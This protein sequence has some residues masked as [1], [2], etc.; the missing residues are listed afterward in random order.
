MN[1]EEDVQIWMDAY[2]AGTASPDVVA[3]LNRALKEDEALRI[4]F[5]H[6]ANLEAELSLVLCGEDP[7]APPLSLESVNRSHAGFETPV[8][9]A[10]V[11]PKGW[12]FLPDRWTW[13]IG[14]AILSAA[15]LVLLLFVLLQSDRDASPELVSPS[16][17]VLIEGLASFGGNVLP[18]GERCEAPGRIVAG[19]DTTV[20]LQYPDGSLLTLEEGSALRLERGRGK[21]VFL[22]QG[23][24]L[25][26]MQPQKP[27]KEM[28]M[29]TPNAT[30]T[31]LGTRYRLETTIIEDL[32]RVEHGKVRLLEKKTNRESIATHGSSSR[33]SGVVETLFPS[34]PEETN[35][36]DE[37][38]APYASYTP[39]RSWFTE[40]FDRPWSRGLWE[41]RIGESPRF[42]P[43]IQP[44]PG[45]SVVAS[46]DWRGHTTKSLRLSR[47]S[48]S[49]PAVCLR[50]SETVGWDS[51]FLK[52]YYRPA[53]EEPPVLNPLCLELPGNSQT[54]TLYQAEG[55][56]L[57]D[58]ESNRWKR[59]FVQYLRYWNGQKWQVEVRRYVNHEHRSTVRLDIERTPAIRLE[60]TSGAALFDSVSVGKLNPARNPLKAPFEDW[61]CT[62]D[63]EPFPHAPLWD[64]RYH[65]ESS[66]YPI[67]A[68][69]REP[70]LVRTRSR[71][72]KLKQTMPLASPSRTGVPS[73][74][75]MCRRMKWDAVL[76]FDCRPTGEAPLL[77][78]PLCLQLPAG[79]RQELAFGTDRHEVSNVSGTW[80][81]VRFEY[82]RL[83]TETHAWIVEAKRFL[84]GEHTST[85]RIHID[86]FPPVLLAVQDGAGQFDWITVNRLEPQ[87]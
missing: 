15:G 83:Q 24:L 69:G 23:A 44:E 63:F 66:F 59:V 47:P 58:D 78:D 22:E 6:A 32:L 38:Q 70:V 79:T 34:V 65:D 2:L 54:E 27:G 62:E 18:L 52:Y 50:L 60:L 4:R 61:L 40:D 25:A 11:S 21:K 3:R 31:V 9:G 42:R 72:G 33:V 19:S 48:G 36:P 45:A 73:Q 67:T 14:S 16:S 26:D 56:E 86:H 51:Y 5:L 12:N 37:P 29:D 80:H 43:W 82:R 53:G 49:G 68:P 7:E 85:I 20:V 35:P 75:R 13:V 74:L 71:K 77:L 46:T 30:V 8:R 41:I 39:N 76:E 10:V 17:L 84:N 81:R 1:H 28:I 87:N 55:S 57:F 64:V